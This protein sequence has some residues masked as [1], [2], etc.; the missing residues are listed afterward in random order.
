MIHDV[1]MT[2]GRANSFNRD[3]LG[4]ANLEQWAGTPI[5]RDAKHC[6][7]NLS[8]S[9]TGT[10]ADP[11]ISEGGRKLLADLL[12]QLT[13]RQLQ[14]LF[15]VARFGNRFLPGGAGAAPVSAWVDAFKHKR[16]EIAANS[17]ATSAPGP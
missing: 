4:S 13:D 2:F 11:I 7:A 1:G 15:E 17:C 6:V 16:D 8:Q 9:Q 5:W 10:L 12:G 3:A 14:D